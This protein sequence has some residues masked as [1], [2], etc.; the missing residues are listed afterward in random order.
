[1]KIIFASLFLSLSL[2]AFQKDIFISK[3]VDY[4]STNLRNMALSF[5]L[6][7]VP[8]NF[9]T[10]KKLLDTKENPL[11]KEKIRLGRRL[12]FETN[13]SKDNSIACSS[14]HMLTEGGDD[15]KAAA[16]GFKGRVNPHHLNTPTVFNA[17]LQKSEFWDGRVENVEEQAGGPLQS[18]F[19]MDMTPDL[20]VKR[21]K[22]VEYYVHQFKRVFKNDKKPLSF[23]NVRYAIGAYEK[24]LL[25]RGNFD[26]FLDGNNSAIN[27]K[28][29]MGLSI[30]LDAGC[31]RCHN[32]MALGGEMLTRF[33]L[34]QK[35][36][37]ISNGVYQPIFN[38]ARFPFKN[39]GNFLGKDKMQIFKVPI[40]R[41]ILKTAPYF[42][43]GAIKSLKKAIDI[44]AK[45]ELGVTLNKVQID[46]IYEFFKSLNGELVDYKIDN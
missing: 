14:C 17:A 5:G 33:P 7:S 31:I 8:K 24:T 38:S 42:H 10:L 27:K 25:T 44:M 43:N 45:Y 36:A 41:N 29:K 21:L 11:T 30:F 2:F 15:N 22:S 32:G 6:K 46:E 39:R 34:K 13:L 9:K 18:S 4:N 28:A 35:V 1:M 23:K 20:V 40:L 12:F 26:R 37:E 3:F 19:E 16:V